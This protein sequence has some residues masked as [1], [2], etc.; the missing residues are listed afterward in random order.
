MGTHTVFTTEPCSGCACIWYIDGIESGTSQPSLDV[1]WKELGTHTISVQFEWEN[2]FSPI[3]D[4][5]VMVKETPKDPIIAPPF[6]SP[7]G[8]GRNDRWK[9]EGIEFWPDAD[10]K[11]YN[12][13]HKLIAHYTGTEKGWDGNYLGHPCV[14]DDY[15]YII[16]YDNGQ[17]QLSGHVTLKR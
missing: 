4:Y 6:F 3:T 15:W 1:E 10:I 5:Q 11:I 17:R 2:C 13:F 12:R 8:D 16:K 7:N 9:L 14:S